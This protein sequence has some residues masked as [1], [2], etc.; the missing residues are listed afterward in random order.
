M[1][2]IK[3]DKSINL[4]GWVRLHVV[5]L[6][7]HSRIFNCKSSLYVPDLFRNGCSG[8]EPPGTEL[9]SEAEVVFLEVVAVLKLVSAQQK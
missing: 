6:C 1:N 3:S 9:S 2:M 8:P 7:S 4:H 5:R